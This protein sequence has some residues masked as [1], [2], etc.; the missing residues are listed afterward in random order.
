M[1]AF[2]SDDEG[3][4]L[5]AVRSLAG[6][7]GLV[8]ETSKTYSHELLMSCMASRIDAA[9]VPRGLRDEWWSP[10][11]DATMLGAVS[12]ALLATPS[13]SRTSDFFPLRLSTWYV[14]A[15][16]TNGGPPKLSGAASTP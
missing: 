16:V 5:A 6:K 10:S 15:S 8:C 13:T 3:K 7:L 4:S 12:D 1:L 14:K 11:S 2:R 9:R